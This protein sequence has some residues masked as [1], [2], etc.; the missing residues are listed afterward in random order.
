MTSASLPRHLRHNLLYRAS[1]LEFF[2]LLFRHMTPT[3]RPKHL[4][5]PAEEGNPVERN[6]LTMK[7]QIQQ[8]QQLGQQ[9]QQQQLQPARGEFG[10]TTTTTTTPVGGAQ[11]N[12]ASLHG[13]VW[14]VSMNR[15]IHHHA[16]LMFK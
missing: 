11:Y 5:Y 3:T 10:Y 2:L 15:F 16:V 1:L 14:G 13:K 7:M 9:Q 12:T 4:I 8:Q 6:P